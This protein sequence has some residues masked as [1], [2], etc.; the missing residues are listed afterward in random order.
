MSVLEAAPLIETRSMVRRLG[1]GAVCGII[2]FSVSGGSYGLEDTI[3]GSGAGL[4]LLLVMITPLVWSLPTAL[5][6]AELGTMMPVQGGYY[7][8]C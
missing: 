4:G 7:H 3:G 5:M 6:V 8:W 2:Y 1:L